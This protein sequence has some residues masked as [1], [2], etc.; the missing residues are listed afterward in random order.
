MGSTP[1]PSSGP[2]GWGCLAGL[3][4]LSTSGQVLSGAPVI[5]WVRQCFSGT[6]VV[7]VCL[8]GEMQSVSGHTGCP[9][10]FLWSDSHNDRSNIKLWVPFERR[11]AAHIFLQEISQVPG[12]QLTFLPSC[13]LCFAQRKLEAPR[14][15][16]PCSYFWEWISAHRYLGP[17]KFHIPCRNLW[18]ACLLPN[19]SQSLMSERS[20]WGSDQ[21]NS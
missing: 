3:R 17:E 18:A 5:A 4:P 21:R 11:Y 7:T 2:G 1:L 6:G 8:P 16:A 14:C 9:L 15:L 20:L 19:G 12:T 13:S 10:R